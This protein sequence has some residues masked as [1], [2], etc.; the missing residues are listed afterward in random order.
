MYFQLGATDQIAYPSEEK[1]N[2]CFDTS[3]V[4]PRGADVLRARPRTT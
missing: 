3:L 4:L 1:K 2:A